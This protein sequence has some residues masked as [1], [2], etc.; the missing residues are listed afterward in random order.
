MSKKLLFQEEDDDDDESP[1]PHHEEPGPNY[2]NDT[3]VFRH[4]NQPRPVGKEKKLLK[5]SHGKYVKKI[6]ARSQT[7]LCTIILIFELI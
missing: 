3:S 4:S 6:R 1:R 5:N 7:L 2:A